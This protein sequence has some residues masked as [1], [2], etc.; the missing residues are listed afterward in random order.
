MPGASSR[1]DVPASPAQ[2]ADRLS[3]DRLV[4]DRAAAAGRAAIGVRPVTDTVKQ[5]D[6]DGFVI[7]TVDRE[8]LRT[9]VVAALPDGRVVDPE[10]A[11]KQSA[12]PELVDLPHD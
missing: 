8:H 11:L 9:P 3:A 7:G 4:A 5:V 2:A 12:S 6:A 1:P 10:V